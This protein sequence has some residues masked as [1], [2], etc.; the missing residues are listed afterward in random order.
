MDFSPGGLITL[1]CAYILD[2]HCRLTDSIKR[3]HVEI[4]QLHSFN[5]VQASLGQCYGI[6][7]ALAEEI[8]DAD[9][10][11]C[12]IHNF[13]LTTNIERLSSTAESVRGRPS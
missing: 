7:A 10:P 3:K 6:C 9:C 11:L 13:P 12:S 5:F 1:C 8:E 2:L 4:K